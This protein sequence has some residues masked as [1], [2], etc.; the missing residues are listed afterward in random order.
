MLNKMNQV[1]IFLR[2]HGFEET[3]QEELRIPSLPWEKSVWAE[4]MNCATHYSP[5]SFLDE[6]F[7]YLRYNIESPAP[8]V[9]FIQR[10]RGN[11]AL[12]DTSEV[13]IFLNRF[14]DGPAIIRNTVLISSTTAL[15]HPAQLSEAI[16]IKTVQEHFLKLYT[17]LLWHDNEKLENLHCFEHAM[18]SFRERDQLPKKWAET[19]QPMVEAMILY[20]ESLRTREWQKDP[21]RRPP[22]LPDTFQYRMW[23]L[24][25]AAQHSSAAQ[26]GDH[27][28]HSR[29]FADQLAKISNSL[30]GTVYHKKFPQLQKAM[31]YLRG[32]DR[33]R[34][35]CYLGDISKTTLSWLTQPDVLR[36]ELAAG[37][38]HECSPNDIQDDQVKARVVALTDSWR[39][40]DSEEVRRLSLGC[41][42]TKC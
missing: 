31:K 24:Q 33:A 39:T 27:E 1:S 5:L 38:V 28:A 20:V 26:S 22:F 17:S 13:Q 10:L 15:L 4:V 30:A 23:I 29:A 32:D 7:A 41:S 18:W 19:H 34:V 25:Y 40:S 9:S 36:V 6:Y 37:F 12:R 8:L 3:S 2:K 42:L 16:T 21:A 11:V 35:A 14:G